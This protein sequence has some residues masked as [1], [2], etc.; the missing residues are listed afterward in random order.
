MGD[1]TPSY[2]G[3]SEARYAGYHV[4]SPPQYARGLGGYYGYAGS[5]PLV[6]LRRWALPVICA[7]GGGGGPPDH[8]L[9]DGGDQGFPWSPNREDRDPQ[10]LQTPWGGSL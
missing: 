9:P 7:S 1:P 8:D 4:G 3:C 10:D 6:Y 5:G 2:Q